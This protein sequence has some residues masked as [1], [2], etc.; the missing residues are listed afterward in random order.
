[1]D[2][3][4]LAT[5]LAVTRSAE[6][7]SDW[8]PRNW[9]DLAVELLLA[10]IDE[11]EIAE[12]AGLPASITG[13]ET[14]PLVTSLYEKHGVPLPDP[15]EAVTLLARLMAT[16]LRLRPATVT[17]PMIRMVAGLA[18]EAPEAD[19]AN[20]CYRSAEY[21]DCDCMPVDRGLEAELEA[22]LENLTPL[23]LPDSVVQVLARPLRRTLPLSQPPH[24][25]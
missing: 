16:D 7:L 21:L 4:A 9:P 24:G 18:L 10:G 25:H 8:R 13:W 12:L 22:K 6:R 5:A 17:A 15:E 11:L 23:A 14:D 20:Q 1:V 2:D 3:E 19:L